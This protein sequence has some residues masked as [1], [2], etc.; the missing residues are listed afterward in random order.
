MKLLAASSDE[1]IRQM[2]EKTASGGLKNPALKRDFFE[3]VRN[4][5]RKESISRMQIFSR[6]RPN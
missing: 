5:T 2:P 6:L 1:L 3:L 4:G